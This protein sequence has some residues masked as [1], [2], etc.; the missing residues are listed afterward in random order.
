M[1]Y[2]PTTEIMVALHASPHSPTGSIVSSRVQVGEMGGMMMAE[3]DHPLA[4]V[5]G[6]STLLVRLAYSYLPIRPYPNRPP[7][8]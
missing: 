7:F 1:A 8:Y 3:A 2:L 6:V 4:E 5:A